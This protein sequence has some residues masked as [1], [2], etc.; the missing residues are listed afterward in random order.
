LLR[1]TGLKIPVTEEEPDLRKYLAKRLKVNE[2]EIVD[3]KIFKQSIDARKPGMIYFVYTVD[4]QVAGESALLKKL[5]NDRD[6][7]VTPTLEY[8]YVTTGRERLASR[9]VIAGTGPAG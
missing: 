5:K 7:S 8:K 6:V 9:P 2:R 1:L 3:F 4:V